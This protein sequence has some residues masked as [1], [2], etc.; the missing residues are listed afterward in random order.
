[1]YLPKLSLASL[2][3]SFTKIV[4]LCEIVSSKFFHSNRLINKNIKTIMY[5]MFVVLHWVYT[6]PGKLTNMPNHGGNR[7]YDLW[8]ASPTMLYW[9]SPSSRF[10]CVIFQ[11]NIIFT[12]AQHCKIHKIICTCIQSYKVV[13]ILKSTFLQ[14]NKLKAGSCQW[15]NHDMVTITTWW[16]G[17]Q[18]ARS[19]QDDHQILQR[20]F[21]AVQV[22][23]H[24]DKMMA[25]T[26]TIR[27]INLRLTFQLYEQIV[28]VH[29]H[30]RQPTVCHHWTKQC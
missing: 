12:R 23:Q 28:R 13:H 19:W 21:K 2:E 18:F 30:M 8:N 14:I 22:S 1:M 24:L 3:T 20:L 15:Q 17:W 4:F 27:G 5:L 25:R 16:R 26:L 11:T 7:T 29:F 9:A 10:E 6:T